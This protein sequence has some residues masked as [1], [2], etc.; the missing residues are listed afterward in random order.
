MFSQAPIMILFTVLIGYGGGVGMS[1]ATHPVHILFS[2]N[3]HFWSCSVVF[4]LENLEPQALSF[5][6]KTTSRGDWTQGGFGPK[7]GQSSGVFTKQFKTGIQRAWLES[8][9]F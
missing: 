7:M 3:F 8:T 9:G 6:V 1:W 2:E 5:P 4:S